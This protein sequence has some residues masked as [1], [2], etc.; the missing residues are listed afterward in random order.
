MVFAGRAR[1]QAAA[2]AHAARCTRSR[3]RSHRV[4]IPL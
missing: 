4:G 1:L 2:H 3:W